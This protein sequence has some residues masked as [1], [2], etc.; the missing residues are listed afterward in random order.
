MLNRRTH[1][2]L[3][4]E[5][6]V[7]ELESLEVKFR[8]NI[9]GFSII[10]LI[11]VISIIAC[12]TWKNQARAPLKMVYLKKVV[13]QADKYLSALMDHGIVIRSGQ[14]IPGKVSYMYEF[15]PNYVSRYLELPLKDAKL[16][17]RID[18]VYK[19]NQKAANKKAKGYLGQAK[20]LRR[21][22]IDRQFKDYL[23]SLTDLTVSQY[24]SFL[25]SATRIKNGDI[26]YNV[27]TTSYRFHSNIT[28][29]SKCLRPFLR[30]DGRPLVNIDL[31]NS[32][33]YISTIILTDPAR[34]S[35]LVKD[36]AFAMLLQT[37]KVSR[38]HDVTKYIDLCISGKIYE[39]LMTEF[40]KEG[41]I[42]TRSETKV[43]LLRILFANNRQPMDKTNKKARQIFIKL[44]PS[45]HKIFSKV[46]GS[47][48]GDTDKSYRR[49]AILLQRIESFLML[50]RVLK[51]ILKE[52]PNM[53]AVTIHDSILTDLRPGN[54]DTIRTII[55]EE[56][57]HFVGLSPQ[58][59]IDSNCG[60]MK[61]EL[62]TPVRS[63]NNTLL[64]TVYVE[65]N[66]IDAQLFCQLS[67]CVF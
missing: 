54:V 52:Y 31:K 37:L 53:V 58:V 1:I 66:Q 14:A 48:S 65:D 46:R 11:E 3:V 28:N 40:G 38:N 16:I 57:T 42:Q 29:I 61:D 55:T 60:G 27:D 35:R 18:R 23:D 56:F 25:T 2:Q 22:S 39:Y 10:N 67:E 15:A 47:K 45:V 24:N 49:F 30:I 64:Q 36:P 34:V 17:N 12:R 8:Q 32:Q 59:S 50:D 26:S 7:W 62:T 21:L 41:L 63:I 9:K 4:P 44:F 33:P 51:R 19:E 43:Q 13:P 20:Y 5:K 6:V